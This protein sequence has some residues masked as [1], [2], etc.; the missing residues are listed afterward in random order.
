MSSSIDFTG[1]NSSFSAYKILESP[2]S[3]IDRVISE[4]TVNK[5]FI[6]AWRPVN[7]GKRSRNSSGIR[8][9]DIFPLFRLPLFFFFFFSRFAD[10]DQSEKNTFRS[11]ATG[12]KTPFSIF[13]TNINS[14]WLSSM[15]LRDFKTR[16]RKTCF[17]QEESCTVTPLSL[18]QLSVRRQERILEILLPIILNLW[19]FLRAK[20]FLYSSKVILKL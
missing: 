19:I 7:R 3:T 13:S 5:V 12:A 18:D 20:N 2:L 6:S 17:W 1:Y 4:D 9:A 11:M 10:R 16:G 8:A 14:N 15:R